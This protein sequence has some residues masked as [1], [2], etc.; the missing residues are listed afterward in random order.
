MGIIRSAILASIVL[1]TGMVA[2]VSVA[3]EYAD[4]VFRNGAVY[5]IDSK[6]PKAQ[7]I[8]VKGKKISYVGSNQGV[9]PL[10]GTNTQII[11][12]KGQ[13]L[14]PGFVESHVHPTMAIVASGADLACDSV[15]EVLA[16]TKAWADAHPDAKLIQGFGWRYTLFSTTGPNKA[17]LDKLFPNK[18]VLL[19]AIDAHSAWMNSKALELAGIDAK[20][21][22]PAPGISFFQRDPKTNEPTGWVVETLAEQQ[23]MA[24][25]NPPTPE[26]V[27]AAAGEFGISVPDA[28]KVVGFDDIVLAQ[29]SQPAL[30]TVRQDV[31]GG[32]R[33]LVDLLIRQMAGAQT[34]SVQFV[35][36]LIQRESA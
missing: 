3:A 11:D 28:M 1:S 35:P 6:Q 33:M 25:L 2:R 17:D 18:P 16:R 31:E 8:A 5:T 9:Q 19:V 24:K 21:P 30:T 23:V 7:A 34:Q 14:L 27:I 4:Y 15:A 22:D 29:L 12:L 36:R 13:M 10:V 26:A 20:T 32:A